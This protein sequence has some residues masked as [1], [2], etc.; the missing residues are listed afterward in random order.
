MLSTLLSPS[1]SLGDGCPAVVEAPLIT[2]APCRE[3]QT[4]TS[5]FS[6]CQETVEV[7][8]AAVRFVVTVRPWA[9]G[10]VP[11]RPCQ[12]SRGAVIFKLQLEA[13]GQ[14]DDSSSSSTR[15]SSI[16]DL[17]ISSKPPQ[18][19]MTVPNLLVRACRSMRFVDE[20]GF[21]GLF[22]WDGAEACG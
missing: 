4:A 8:F 14:L 2:A 1:P 18:R 16:S 21:V 15:S 6:S 5:T 12:G 19:Q 3:P 20:M 7:K 13:R 10:I 17:S 9:M 22:M 11:R